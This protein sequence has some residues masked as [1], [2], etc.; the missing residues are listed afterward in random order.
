MS[1]E[2]FSDLCADILGSPKFFRIVL[3]VGGTEV[4]KMVE[5]KLL[6]AKKKKKNIGRDGADWCCFTYIRYRTISV[7][8]NVMGD[9]F[10]QT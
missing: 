8:E 3:I 9:L 4:M 5:S 2:I 7:I 10:Q 1:G 6:L